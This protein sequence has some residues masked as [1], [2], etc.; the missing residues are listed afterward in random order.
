MAKLN[1]EHSNKFEIKIYKISVHGLLQ[2]TTQNMVI[3]RCSLAENG[4]EMYQES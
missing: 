2:Q 4:E 1:P 3:L